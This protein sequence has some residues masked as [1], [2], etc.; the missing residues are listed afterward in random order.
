MG[1][2]ANEKIVCR[3]AVELLRW[4]CWRM[5]T[6]MMEDRMSSLNSGVFFYDGATRIVSWNDVR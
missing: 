4:I 3:N 6:G 5:K 1:V 2:G